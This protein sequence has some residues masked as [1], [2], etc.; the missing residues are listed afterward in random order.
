MSSALILRNTETGR[1]RGPAFLPADLR[2]DPRS[3]LYQSLYKRLRGFILDGA[4][5]P[6]TRVPSSRV[7]AADLNVSRNT[8]ILAVEQLIAD[9]W[10]ESRSR[11]GVYVSGAALAVR[12]PEATRS[13][14]AELPPF[15]LQRPATDLFPAATWKQLQTRA[16]GEIEPDRLLGADPAGDPGLREAIARLVCAPRGLRCHPDQILV[17]PSATFA[18][19][20]L[21]AALLRPGEWTAIEEPTRPGIRRLLQARG[22]QLHSVPVDNE[23]LD[24]RVLARLT[25][26]PSVAWTTPAAHFPTGATLSTS[27]RSA[28]IDWARAEGCWIVEDD[29]DADAWFDATGPA[30]P[31]AAQCEDRTLLI[32]SFNRLLFPGLCVA[33]LVAPLELVDR[34]RAVQAGI[35][36]RASLA[37]Q[38]ALRDFIAEGHL[39]RH[40]RRRRAG[41]AERRQA[42]ADAL[43]GPALNAAGL[44]FVLD[45]PNAS[46]AAD[47]L[48]SAGLGGVPLAA[49]QQSPA[50]DRRLALGLG[51][52]LDT[53]IALAPQLRATLAPSQGP[54]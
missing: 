39:A 32:G 34:L 28:L 37:A 43:E 41:Y 51:A 46:A 16:W 33:F 7:L 47:R 6:G 8:A 10:A 48:G 30:P 17:V 11:S 2:P 15:A 4:W 19:D 24:P 44:H 25:P 23:G 9:G 40:L 21:A 22:T 18:I 12:A 14:P 20:L 52:N 36:G 42:L 29:R 53:I 26:A 27:R 54:C 35:G 50:E 5:P 31:I 49:F 45:V 13:A 38:L 1:S 3:G